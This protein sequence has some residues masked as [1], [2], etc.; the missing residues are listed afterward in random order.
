MASV[1]VQCC[2][3]SAALLIAFPPSRTVRVPWFS[4]HPGHS[5]GQQSCRLSILCMSAVSIFYPSNAATGLTSQTHDKPSFPRRREADVQDERPND[6]GI[7]FDVVLISLPPHLHN[8]RSHPE[9]CTDATFASRRKANLIRIHEAVCWTVLS[10]A[11]GMC[12]ARPQR[13]WGRMTRRRVVGQVCIL[14]SPSPSI[15]PVQ[16][17]RGRREPP[18]QLNPAYSSKGLPAFVWHKSARCP[19]FFLV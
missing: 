6:Q 13:R 10:Q 3:T 16:I 8:P 11:S 7:G 4:N 15:S 9:A 14:P 5:T 2:T 19:L 12:T 18:F 1:G 17:P